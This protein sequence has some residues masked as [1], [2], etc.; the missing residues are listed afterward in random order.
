MS[1]TRHLSLLRGLMAVAALVAAA[2]ASFAAANAV[3]T[4]PAAAS[5]APRSG[6]TAIAAA[7]FAAEQS[8][9]AVRTMT[10]TYTAHTGA[11]R[12]A[13][14]L[15]P[16]AYDGT[17]LPLVISPH[18][19]GGSGAGNAALWGSLPTVGNFV[20]VNPDGAGDRLERFSWGAQGQVDDLA[21]MPEIVEREL[22]WLR[23]DRHRIYAFGGSMGGQETLLLVA[24]HPELLAG[25]A[26][27]D[28]L[29][30][31]PHQYAQFPRLACKAPCSGW[32]GSLG[33]TL[34]RL[35]RTE[36]GGTPAGAPGEYAARSPI[37]H[38]REIA[39]SDVPLQLWWSTEDRIVVD[40]ST[41][42]GALLEALRREG[43]KAPVLA[44]E[45]TWAHTHE[46]RAT[47]LL[48]HALAQF[49]L[50]PAQ[51][52]RLPTGAAVESVVAAVS[53]ASV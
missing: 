26:A 47:A 34:Q 17:P 9:A 49:G 27:F 12:S 3:A 32:G 38:A 11:E 35:A 33:R 30:D 42:S 5:L 2:L 4:T 28:S 18:G 41:Q 36:V 15:A 21:R 24:G 1:A 53:T 22:P 7:R 44:F 19:R 23:V 20:V 40:S 52:R 43:P 31:F 37:A 45:G 51:Y 48:P 16:L 14:V 29:V 10:I 46:M 25:A 39:A 50:M 13:T 6:T 8:A